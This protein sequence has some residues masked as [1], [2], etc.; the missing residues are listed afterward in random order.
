MSTQWEADRNTRTNLRSPH[1]F[2]GFIGIT[3]RNENHGEAV[4]FGFPTEAQHISPCGLGTKDRVIDQGR[5]IPFTPIHDMALFKR[6][7]QKLVP[8]GRSERRPEEV[9]TALRV[10]RS[11]FDSSLRT[12][13]SLQC[14]YLR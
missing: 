10:T 14:P 6:M 5:E 9:H 13:K 8:Q 7:M 2:Y 12:D 1:G 11:P 3:G 4:H